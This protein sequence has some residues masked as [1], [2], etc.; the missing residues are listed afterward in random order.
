MGWF[1]RS[2]TG[3][4]LMG[5]FIRRDDQLEFVKPGT[6]F[7]RTHADKMVETAEVVSVG[8]DSFGIPH[9]QFQVS[10]WRP[11]RNFFDGGT[12]MLALRSF[13]DRYTERVAS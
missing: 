3:R 2:E 5:I 6:T 1:N 8:T 10:F 13:A 9:V 11:H 12:R 7:R 4:A